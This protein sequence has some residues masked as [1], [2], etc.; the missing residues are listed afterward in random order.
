MLKK[1]T[2]YLFVVVGCLIAAG[3]IN[4][5]LV[6]HHLLSGGLAGLGIICYYLF[7]IPAGVVTL[8]L[9]VPLL[10]AAWRMLGKKYVAEVLF[11]TV[12]FSVCLDATEF[13]SHQ[14]ITDDIL[15]AAIYGGVFNGI[16]FGILFRLGAS[17]GGMDIAAA[18]VKKYYS[19]NMGA[20]V[21]SINCCIMVMAA[22]LFGPAPAMYTLISMFIAG[23]LSDMLTAGFNHRK[24]VIIISRSPQEIAEGII[25]ELERGATFLDGSGAFYRDEKQVVFSVVR[26]TEIARLKKIVNRVDPTAFMI[27]IDANEVMGRGFTLSRRTVTDARA[28]GDRRLIGSR[29]DE[30]PEKI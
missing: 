22:F 20:V 2:H 7:G 21:F 25:Q 29:F 8:A 6:Q 19:F 26:M 17:S 13:M 4:V 12:M 10:I 3:S 30:T 24:A 9:N 28:A 27:F 1:F 23:R 15:L 18:I 14:Y 11:A 16:G 5:F